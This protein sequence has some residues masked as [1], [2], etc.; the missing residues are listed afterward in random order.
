MRAPHS[1]ATSFAWRSPSDEFGNRNYEHL[2]HATRLFVDDEATRDELL[3]HVDAAARAREAGDSEQEIAVVEHFH[4]SLNAA[5]LSAIGPSVLSPKFVAYFGVRSA[6]LA[7]RADAGIS[8]IFRGG[9]TP[10]GTPRAGE[11]GDEL[12]G[13][14]TNEAQTLN[15]HQTLVFF[16][17]G[18]P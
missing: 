5:L 1:I 14:D 13:Q 10:P 17:G 3:G 9:A 7:R 18:I 12:R 11:I 2:A 16:L 15:H 8:G 4:E 6:F